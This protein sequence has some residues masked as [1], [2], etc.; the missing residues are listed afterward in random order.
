MELGIV[1]AWRG[2]AVKEGMDQVIQDSPRYSEVDLVCEC[3][4]LVV[5][6]Q[7]GPEKR[8]RTEDWPS[9][10]TGKDK[11]AVMDCRRREGSTPLRREGPQ[12]QSAA[13]EHKG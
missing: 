1:G 11:A 10:R 12:K 13:Q 5:S 7:Q 4:A 9:G 6:D 8:A 3:E 2:P